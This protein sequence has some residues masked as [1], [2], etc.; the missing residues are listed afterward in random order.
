MKRIEEVHDV[1]YFDPAEDYMAFQPDVILFWEAPY[2]SQSPFRDVW[3][4]VVKTPVRKALLFAGGPIKKEW[5]KDF[6]HVFVE[7]KINKDEFDALGISNSTAFGINEEIMVPMK[8]EKKYVGIHHGTCAS[9]KRQQ[10]VGES[11]GKDGLVVGRYQ[12]SDRFPFD[13]CKRLGTTVLDEQQPEQIAELLN[14]SIMCLQ[15]SRA[16]GGGQRCTL[17]AMACNIPVICTSDS[18]KNR[19]YVEESG[20][21][22]VCAPDSPHIKLAI[23]EV[24]NREWGNK[25]RDY[26]MTKWTSKHYADNLLAWINKQI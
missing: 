19:E 13:E 5:V 23:E 24:K 18:P 21:G 7:S 25:G 14:E 1:K 4:K 20:F 6:D 15:T 8:R 9:W 10:L 26:I 17:E 3:N 11:L 16:D 12:E 2:T 22:V